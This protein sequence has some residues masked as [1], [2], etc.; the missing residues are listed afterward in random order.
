MTK[1]A[2]LRTTFVGNSTIIN[3][4]VFRKRH[5]GIGKRSGSSTVGRMLLTSKLDSSADKLDQKEG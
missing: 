5:S 3:F 4:F 1:L 2:N